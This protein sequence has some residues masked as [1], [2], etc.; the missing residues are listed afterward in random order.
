M[1]KHAMEHCMPDMEKELFLHDFETFYQQL[2]ISYFISD[3]ARKKI[4]FKYLKI[5]VIKDLGK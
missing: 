1:L 3:S 4:F 5:K 2:K